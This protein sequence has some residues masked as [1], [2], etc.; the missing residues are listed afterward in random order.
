MREIISACILLLFSFGSLCAQQHLVDS[1]NNELKQTMPDSSRAMSMMR[2]AI[3][4]EAIDTT[5]AYEGYRNAI[6]FASQKN[7][8]YQ[9][10]RIYQNQSILYS[11]AANYPQAIASLDSAIANYK[12]SDHPKSKLWEANAYNNKANTLKVQNEFQQAVEYYLKSIS[13]MEELKESNGLVNKYSNL[14]TLFGDMGENQKQIEFAHKAVS[15]AREQGVGHNLFFAYFILANAYCVKDDMAAAKEFIDSSTTYFNGAEN[16]DKIDILFSYYLVAAQVYKKMNQPDS[17]FYLFNKAYQVSKSYNYAYGM[18]EAQL[19]MGAIAIIQEKYNEAEKYLLAGIST[20][21]S[22]NYYGILNNGYKY[23]ADVY[24]VKGKYREAYEYFQ[25]HKEVNDSLVNMESRKY[26][27]ELE[28]K[29]ESAKKDAKLLQQQSQIQRK[30]TLNY[31]LIGAAALFLI[32]SFL[33]FWNYRQKQ[34]L[35]QQRISELETEKQLAATEAVLK[36]EEQERTRLA[37]DLHDGL[38]GMLSGIKYSLNTMKG[39]LIMTPDNARAF[40]RSVDMLDS[41]IKE[42][43][44]VAHNMMPEA[45]VKFGLDTA[46]RDFCNDI[47]RSGALQVNYQSIGMEDPHTD[48][49][50]NITIYRIVQELLNNAIKHAGAGNAIVQ[51]NKTDD[52]ISITVED[53]GKGFDTAVLKG[54]QGIGW[55]NIQSRVEYLKGRF[56]VRSAPGKGT[57]VMVEIDCKNSL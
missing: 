42:M 34:K 27:S 17:A 46:L 1:I 49:I 20:A 5:K 50:T 47:N 39:N 12:I 44:R 55:H 15:A 25:R 32:I 24:A 23:L 30:N 16:L 37:K 35:Q 13:L 21:R 22:I 40:E 51:V 19:Q 29:Y 56:D 9:L 43:R 57:S 52:E 4:Y 53:D 48:Q 11:T 3:N 7:L 18:A 31:I 33:S 41:S 45:L 6:D 26:A 2:L 10:G 28:K 54:V 14:A 8:Y 38:G 36:G